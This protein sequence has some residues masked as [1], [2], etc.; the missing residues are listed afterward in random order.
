MAD[1]YT[2]AQLGVF[3]LI[4]AVVGGVAV[5]I[6]LKAPSKFSGETEEEL[7][8]EGERMGAPASNDRTSSR[9]GMSEGERSGG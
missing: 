5:M 8:D 7:E 1:S 4:N 3:A 9:N 2:P 6:S